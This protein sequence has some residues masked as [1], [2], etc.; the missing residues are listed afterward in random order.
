MTNLTKQIFSVIAAGALVVNTAGVAFADTT[1]QISGNGAGS[2]NWTTV[3]QN[4]TTAV[5]QSN[6]AN[7]SNNVNSSANTG[8]NDANFNTGGNVT[9]DTGA[10]KT[11]TNV[12]NTLN[13][14]SADVNCGSCAGG[15]TDVTVSGNGGFSDQGVKLDSNSTTTVGQTNNANVHNNVNSDASTGDNDANLNTGGDVTVHTGDATTHTNVSTAANSNVA[16]VGAGLGATVTPTASF[17]ILGNGAGSNNSIDADLNQSAVLGQTNSAN[18]YNDVNSDAKTGH[19]DANFNTGGDVT[20]VT[21]NAKT[22]TGV[23]NMVN[24]NAA[25]IDCGCGFGVLAKIDGNG[26]DLPWFE[27]S[28]A[29]NLIQLGLNNTQVYGQ[30][31]NANLQNDDVNGSAYT[32]ANDSNLNTGAVNVMNDPA[33]VTGN[34]TSNTQVSNSGNQNVIGQLPSLQLGNTN[35]GFNFNWEAFLGFFGLSM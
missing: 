7:V 9:V 6:T 13:S 28:D 34:A 1:I 2:D 5:Q 19:N 12:D 17:K 33:L 25:S 27:N 26:A 18:V 21:G 30:G 31:N 10:A 35:V 4:N 8:G 15:N 23:D 3:S 14:N 11:T 24:F 20:I 22:T 16:Q 29:Q 32:G